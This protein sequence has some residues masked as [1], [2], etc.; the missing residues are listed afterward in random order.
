MKCHYQVLEVDVD[1][2]DSQ[3]KASYRRLALRWHPD[4][5]IENSD[6]A[7]E[8]FQLI[9]QAYE[10][11]SDSHERAW[12]DRH[13][14]QI[15]KGSQSNYE[16]E[17]LDVYQYFSASC[18]KGFGDDEGG[19][20]HV[21]S[22]IFH[23]IATE[24]L[25]F[26]DDEDEFD[27]IPK[28]GNSTSDYETVVGPFYGYWQSY[29]TKKSY[30]WLCPHNINEI[31]DRRILREIEKETKK[32]AQK[33]RKDRNEEVRALVSFVRKRDKR[34]QQYKLV[35]EEKAEQN[36]LKQNQKR[37]EQI[38]KNRLEVENM[39]KSSVF[40]V[41]GY[42]EM[43]RQMEKT[44]ASSDD[45][46][47]DES[48]DSDVDE[49]VDAAEELELNGK[50]AEEEYI[51][52]LYC[53]ACNKSFKNE[54]SFKNHETSKKH[55]KMLEEDANYKLN[56]SFEENANTNDSDDS[57]DTHTVEAVK[58][59]KKSKKKNRSVVQKE[60][61]SDVEEIENVAEH[62]NTNDSNE[63]D[64]VHKVEPTKKSKKS[65]KKNRPVVASIP[66]PE[67]GEI[68][69]VAEPQND[70]EKSET[71]EKPRK[72]A[73]A[74]RLKRSEQANNAVPV[75]ESKEDIDTAHVCVT[76]KSNFDSKNKLFA[77]LKKTNHGVYIPKE[78]AAPVT[79]NAKK[80]KRK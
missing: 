43:L 59:S 70:D 42:E 68:E 22:D 2:D 60:P 61:D 25:E 77:H 80:G 55:L 23:Q 48:G 73:K 7:K 10:V 75:A 36:R 19:F 38:K 12:Y 74:K 37:L 5:N 58:R 14:D 39:A 15:L 16:D 40:Q 26:M 31:R 67:V 65:K 50:T 21:Y 45:E 1:A 78:T 56:E 69:N 33:A 44:Y 13:K 76:C 79:V 3:I 62:I 46:E 52:H 35:L 53:V 9:Q 63:S 71:I 51:D 20:Y 27:R 18:Y 66:D 8:K 29:S 24:D 32:L 57:D 41:D 49:V 72:S 47:Y 11:L 17:S 6:E 34:V 30:S 28:F 64:D 54:S 4:K